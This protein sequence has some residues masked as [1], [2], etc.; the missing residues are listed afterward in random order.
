MLVTRIFDTSGKY[1]YFTASTNRGPRSVLPRC[2]LSSSIDSQRVRYSLVEHLAPPLAP[3]ATKKRSPTQRWR[4]PDEKK[5]R[6]PAAGGARQRPV[7]QRR[8][9]QEGSLNRSHRPRRTD[10]RI[11]ALL[12]SRNYIGLQA[13]KANTIFVVELCRRL[14]RHLDRPD[15]RPFRLKLDLKSGV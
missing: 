10:Q 2:P 6:R 3:K 14:P 15:L 11:I 8:A 1:L 4:Q 12:S 7:V 5:R 9:I 13:G